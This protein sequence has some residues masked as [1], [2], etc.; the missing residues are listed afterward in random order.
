MRRRRFIIDLST[1]AGSSADLHKLL[2]EKL[3][4]PDYY[5][6][7]LDALHDVLTEFGSNWTLIFRGAPPPGLKEVCDDAAEE[8]PGLKVR[9]IRPRK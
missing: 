6:G 1:S 2:R 9:W 8:T 3:P 7:N 4:L 5:G